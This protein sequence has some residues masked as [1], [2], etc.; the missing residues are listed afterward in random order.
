V[1]SRRVRFSSGGRRN[2]V[3]KEGNVN[4]TIKMNKRSRH[5]RR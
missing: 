5:D 1:I 2:V 4:F 3:G